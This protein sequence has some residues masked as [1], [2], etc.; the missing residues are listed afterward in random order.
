[1]KIILNR[2]EMLDTLVAQSQHWQQEA[3]MLQGETGNCGKGPPHLLA[4]ST[5]LSAEDMF[6]TQIACPHNEIGLKSVK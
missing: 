2:D 3:G 1:M 6:M 4:V 5:G